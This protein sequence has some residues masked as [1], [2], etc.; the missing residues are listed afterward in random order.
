MSARIINC[1]YYAAIVATAAIASLAI[2]WRPGAG[3]GL[4]IHEPEIWWALVSLF[5]TVGLYLY[6]KKHLEEESG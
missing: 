4:V 1:A 2:D 5:V 3:T 6:R